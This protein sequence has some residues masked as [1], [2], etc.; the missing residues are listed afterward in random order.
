MV[1]NADT[2]FPVNLAAEKLKLGSLKSECYHGAMWEQEGN[3]NPLAVGWVTPLP[4]P[5]SPP[6]SL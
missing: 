4:L 2:Y 6:P 5:P 3:D 1:A